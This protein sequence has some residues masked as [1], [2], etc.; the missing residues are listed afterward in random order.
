MD[1]HRLIV[2][3]SAQ[4]FTSRVIQKIFFQQFSQ[5]GMHLCCRQNMHQKPRILESF[6]R[7]RQILRYCLLVVWFC[8]YEIIRFQDETKFVL[9]KPKLSNYNCYTLGSFS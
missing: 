5:L 2:Q 8:S 3:S 7:T 9:I 6:R 4:S 1:K